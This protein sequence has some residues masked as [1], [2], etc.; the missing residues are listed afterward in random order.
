MGAAGGVVQFVV[1][2]LAVRLLLQERGDLFLGRLAA[3]RSEKLHGLAV[4]RGFEKRFFQLVAG[5][6]LFV[7]LL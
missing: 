3:V 1:G 6:D 2:K 7:K 4:L 5:R